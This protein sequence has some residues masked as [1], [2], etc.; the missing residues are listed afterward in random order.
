MDNNCIQ[1]RVTGGSGGGSGGE[2][3]GG[4]NGGMSYRVV[5]SSE[6]ET[7]TTTSRTSISSST[8]ALSNVQVR[9]RPSLHPRDVRVIWPLSV[10]YHE[11]YN[12]PQL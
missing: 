4:S 8:S 9:P 2:S 10:S 6:G 3:S 5:N 7:T 11:S 12:P 1:Y